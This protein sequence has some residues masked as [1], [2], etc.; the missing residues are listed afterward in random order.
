MLSLCT[1]AEIYLL[2][3]DVYFGKVDTIHFCILILKNLGE[4]LYNDIKYS[5][6]EK[7]VKDENE[8]EELNFEKQ[9]IV[10]DYICLCFLLEMISF[11]ISMELIY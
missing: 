9:D 6:L 4:H 1:G 8:E 2:R 5:I 7:I 11:L 3:E 10:N